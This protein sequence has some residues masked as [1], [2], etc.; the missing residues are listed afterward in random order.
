MLLDTYSIKN[1]NFF[2]YPDETESIKKIQNNCEEKHPEKSGYRLLQLKSLRHCIVTGAYCSSHISFL[3]S[4]KIWVSDNKNNLILKNLLHPQG[5]FQCVNYTSLIPHSF[6]TR[7]TNEVIHYLNDVSSGFGVHTTNNESELIFIGVDADIKILSKDMK[8]S[9]TIVTQGNT[10]WVPC[11]LCWSQLKGDLL[12]GMYRKNDKV[13]EEVFCIKNEKIGKVV[14][15]NLAGEMTQ[16]VQY[17][18]TGK[19]IYL[20]PYYISENNNGD[21]VVCDTNAVVVTDQWGRHCFTYT[22]RP[23]GPFHPHGICIDEWSNILVSGSFPSKVDVIEKNGKFITSLYI[24]DIY[25][26]GGL[27]YDMNTRCLFVGSQSD[28][29]V[30]VLRYTNQRGILSNKSE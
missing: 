18:T 5:E 8:T 19:E 20:E 7:T 16:T 28:N 24:N 27:C 13:R 25:M 23:P 4:D 15:Y 9:T 17:D 10:S 6:L 30:R 3:S 2:Y 12:V 11:C 14:R 22:G 26:S 29:I 21:I 1:Y